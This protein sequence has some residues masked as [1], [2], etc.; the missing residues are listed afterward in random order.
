MERFEQFGREDDLQNAIYALEHSVSSTSDSDPDKPSR[1]NNLCVAFMRRFELLGDSRDLDH[2][3]KSGK[4]ALAVSVSAEGNPQKPRCLY[5][6]ACRLNDRFERLNEL[7]DINSVIEIG[8]LAFSLTAEGDELKPMAL[9]IVACSF[10][11]RFKR[12]GKFDDL[13]KS[14]SEGKSAADLMPKD[15]PQRFSRLHGLSVRLLERFDLFDNPADL[16]EAI[17]KG[18]DA[19]NAM[20]SSCSDRPG[21]LNNLGVCIF[22][23]FEQHRDFGDLT[24]AISLL[25]KAL[26]GTTEGCVDRPRLLDNLGLYVLHRFLIAKDA[27]DLDEAISA[28]RRALA[29]TPHGYLD[30]PSRLINLM[31]SLR[32]RFRVSRQVDDLEESISCGMEAL[33][34]IPD[35]HPDKPSILFQ[36]GA[37]V[38]LRFDRFQNPLDADKATSLLKSAA[39]SPTGSLL[40]RLDAAS[41]WAR[42]LI[43][44]NPS[45]ALEAFKV[46]LDLFPRVAWTGKRAERYGQLAHCDDIV[47]RAAVWALQCGYTNTALEWLEMGRAVVWGQL[48]NLRSPIDF[49]S[50]SHPDLAERL[51]EVTVA[52]ETVTIRDSKT[53]HFK[54]STMEDIAKGQRRLA[55]ECDCLVETVRALPG[56][57]DF[58]LPTKLATLKNA[59]KF[60]PVVL[61]N[62]HRIRCD[63]LVLNPGRDNVFHI[64]LMSFSYQKAKNLQKLIT[65]LL[66]CSGH[67]L[68]GYGMSNKD[69]FMHVLKEL[70]TC[71]VKP[72][73][74]GLAFSP[75]DTTNPPRLWWCPTGPLAFLPIHAAG[76]YRS[77]EPGTKIS[78]YVVSSYTPTLTIL[79][80]K[81]EKTRRFKGLLAISQPNTPGLFPLPGTKEELQKIEERA[82]G[83][84]VEYLRGEEAM[85]DMV[86]DGMSTC[87]WVHMACRCTQNGEKSKGSA[88]H[89]HPSPKYPEGHLPVSH[90]IAKTFPDAD[91][92]YLSACQ[93]ATRDKS[94]SEESVHF[95]VGMLMAGYQ[96][97]I[98]TLWSIRDAD[99]PL[100]A[101]EVYSRLF[102]D[103]E[104]DS[105][106]A[107]IALHHAV[108]SF[109]KHVEGEPDSFLRWVPFIHVG[110]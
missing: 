5:T 1:L 30:K 108:Q 43:E 76:D 48:H 103:G 50:D 45:S 44:V 6:L 109:R 2:A 83:V 68:P 105:G 47:N 29:C 81:L 107:A 25:K 12:L 34:L 62:V 33:S 52:L 92:A 4:D 64:P 90:L 101:D 86:L 17:V 16:D 85:P 28:G 19:V 40:T 51:S 94:L 78:D 38:A 69:G 61:I 31:Q 66:Y 91:F 36:I 95:A 21:V 102:E 84:I 74:D 77:N 13:E 110:V 26:S 9:H 49:L 99:A 10:F 15:Y 73:L 27:N 82:N 88:F 14:I 63:A 100:V 89:L 93:T 32:E 46:T 55:T 96:S 56:F 3:I 98:A 65:E 35:G 60:G 23:R 22:R 75:C 104:P 18:V 39:L 59:A 54:E 11:E 42:V 53:E 8:Q 24:K 67:M 106:N 20:P 58:L 97:V 79:L 37:S 71:I 70:W 72:V 7:D 57:E 41:E 80:D 87:N